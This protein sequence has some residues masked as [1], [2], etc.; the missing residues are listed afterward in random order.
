MKK[1]HHLLSAGILLLCCCARLQA[2]EY[3]THMSKTFAVNT[4]NTSAVL[5]VYNMFGSVKVEGYDG[6]QVV[7][8]IDQKITAKSQDELEKGK[9]E[10]KFQ[11]EQLHDSI[12]VY[13]SAPY[14]S[15]PKQN[16]AG[17][18]LNKRIQYKY[19]LDLV[20][21]VPRAM[22]L[23]VSTIAEG[24]VEITDVYGNL[25]VSNVNGSVNIKNAKGITK[26]STVNGKLNISYGTNPPDASDYRTVN[27]DITVYYKTS[28]DAE[29]FF[30]SMNGSYY[31]DFDNIEPISKSLV[32]NNEAKENKAVYRIE[33]KSG[34]KIGNGGRQ[35]H[36]ETLNGNVYIKKS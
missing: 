34:I 33:R 1:N 13:I 16:W 10:F 25:F 3:K 19:Y 12:V 6:D 36:F 26:A 28:L 27:G 17:N 22:H 35:F 8:E 29:L 30:K 5:A 23:R 15:R 18:E 2:Q 31:T 21:K 20:V 9:A 32:K 7:L 24:N 14:D 11:T 4:K